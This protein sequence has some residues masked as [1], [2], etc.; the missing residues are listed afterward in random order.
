M[1]NSTI[2][3][4]VVVN[5]D[6]HTVELRRVG[7]HCFISKSYEANKYSIASAYRDLAFEALRLAHEMEHRNEPC[8]LHFNSQY[9]HEQ[10]EA[11]ICSNTVLERIF[12]NA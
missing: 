9:A 5:W 8:E 11:A 4:K 3:F 7:D 1:D 6:E 10:A 2:T 12:A